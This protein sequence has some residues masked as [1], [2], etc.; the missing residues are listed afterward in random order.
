MQM[1]LLPKRMKSS[2]GKIVLANFGYTNT[3]SAG[4]VVY[5]LFI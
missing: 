2:L 4:K 5:F 1:V 3:N